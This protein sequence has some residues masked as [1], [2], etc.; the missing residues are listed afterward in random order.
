MPRKRTPRV[1]RGK[2]EYVS[3]QLEVAMS[4]LKEITTTGNG[5]DCRWIAS[6]TLEKLE[7]TTYGKREV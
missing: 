7:S 4:A 5:G 3:A 6:Q 2:L 1:P